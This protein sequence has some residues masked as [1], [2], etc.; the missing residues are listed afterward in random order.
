M[1]DDEARKEYQKV[2][3]ANRRMLLKKRG[4]CTHCGGRRARPGL[5]ECDTCARV[6]ERKERQWA[7][8]GWVRR[9]VR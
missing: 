3:Q 8:G 1:V 9:E 6:G 5:T 4:L 2:Y 7:G